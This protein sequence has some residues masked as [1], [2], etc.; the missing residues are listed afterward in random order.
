MRTIDDALMYPVLYVADELI[1]GE[2]LALIS[3]N[4]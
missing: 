4:P 3:H 1:D 2:N